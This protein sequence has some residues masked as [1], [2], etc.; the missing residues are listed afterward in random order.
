LIIS[1]PGIP[2]GVV[3]EQVRITDVMPTILDL[4]RISAP[5]AVQGVSLTPAIRGER[6]DVLAL[7]ESWYPRYHYGWSELTSVRD[8][9]YEFVGAPHR[10]LYDTQTDSGETHDLAAENPRLADTLERLL[11]Q[12]TSKTSA[13][14]TQAP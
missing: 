11:Q 4:C 1:G 8:G 14:K 7:S 9:R 6:V 3:S 2:A 12:M 5:A 13:S 10:E